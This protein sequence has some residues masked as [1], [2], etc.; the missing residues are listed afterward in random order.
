[1]VEYTGA[2][3]AAVVQAE[4]VWLDAD[5]TIDK[6]IGLI[7]EAA[8]A[9]ARLIAFPE[10]FVPG[11]P[12]WL[13]LDSPAA[14][15][16][17]VGRYHENSLTLDGPRFQ[18]LLDAARVNSIAVALGFSE[19]GGGSLYMGQAV[20][21]ADGKLV[22]ARRKLKPTHVER[23]MFG[24]GDGSDLVVHDTELGRVGALCC[25]EHLQPLTKYAMFSQHEQVHVAAWPSFSVY[26]GAAYA[27][28]P[29]VNT[30]A[31]QIYAA[32]GQVFVLVPCAVVGEAAIELFCDTPVK[33]QLLQRGGGFARI[34]GPDGRP[35]ADPLPEDTEGILYADIDLTAIPFAK[36]AADPVGHYARPDVTRLL[37]N[38]AERRPVEYAAYAGP[39]AE[40]F[41]DAEAIITGPDPKR[42]REQEVTAV[43]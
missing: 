9:G 22:G 36:A 39:S 18:R 30:A 23:T 29:E 5:A 37:L 35:L 10:T 31:S 32:E 43:G 21:S 33:Q 42:E 34:Y 1:M 28:G 25:W 16:Q 26:K 24:E 11:Y 40:S 13:W 4:P 3:K 27:L 12:W 20:I 38:R 7:E 6:S 8:R 19:R 17:F 14:G 2:F 41:D 15:M